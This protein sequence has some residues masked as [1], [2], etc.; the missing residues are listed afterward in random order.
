MPLLGITAASPETTMEHERLPFEAVIDAYAN[1]W[2]RGLVSREV[3]VQAAAYAVVIVPDVHAYLASRFAL[4]DWRVAIRCGDAP[5]T[6]WH[7]GLDP[8]IAQFFPTLE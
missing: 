7:L 6:A 2:E 1:A 4:A 3:A 8:L 5:S